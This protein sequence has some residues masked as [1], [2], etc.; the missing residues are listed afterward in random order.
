MKY[1]D[2]RDCPRDGEGSL[3]AEMIRWIRTTTTDPKFKWNSKSMNGTR[4]LV[5]VDLSD[6]DAIMLKLKYNI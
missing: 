5:G 2:L 4:Y 1:V 6:E 3:D